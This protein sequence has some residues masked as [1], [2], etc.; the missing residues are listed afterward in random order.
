MARVNHSPRSYSARTVSIDQTG[1]DLDEESPIGHELAEVAWESGRR[2]YGALMGLTEAERAALRQMLDTADDL[3]RWRLRA[4]RVE[5]PERGSELDVDDAIFQRIAI[6]QLSRM[7]LVTAGE[8]LRLALD[9]I[10]ARQ[11]YPSSHFT[12][13]RGALVGASQA[14]WILGP[15]DGHVR[16]ERGLTV[17]TEMYAQMGK[18]YGFLDS[19][20]LAAN[21]RL[22]LTDQ[23]MWLSERRQEVASLRKAKAELN[24]TEVIGAA[25]DCA[26]AEATSRDAVRRMWREMSADAHVLG[27]SLFQRTT[28]GPADRRTGVG[29]GKAP[30]SLEHVAEPFL[31]SYRLLRHGWSLFDRRCEEPRAS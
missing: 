19:T 4:Q 11:V 23:R 31:A 14:V 7:S 15:Q 6:S 5:V 30:G 1:A 12:V 13:L 20:N 26:F 21:D 2:C 28:F 17:V 29:E 3:D 22:D 18:Y 25:A 16:R 27:W 24:L 9:A 8:H 10:K